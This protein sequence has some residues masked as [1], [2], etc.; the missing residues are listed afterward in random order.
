MKRN[1]DIFIE[2]IIRRVRGVRET[3]VKAGAVLLGL[4][5][6]TAVFIFLRIFFPFFFALTCLLLFFVFK[7]TIKEYEYSFIN[8]DLDID[9][10]LGMRKRKRV[11]ST[12]CRDIKVMAPCSQNETVPKGEY[13]EVL[14]ASRCKSDPGR[15]YFICRREDGKDMLV[16]FSPSERLR[17]AFKTYLGVRMKD[18]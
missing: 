14:D 3:L 16:F 11:F 4:I 1:E 7:Y 8:G 12:G 15:W 13:A 6:M 10:I 17:N 5:L 2:E 9:V 18:G